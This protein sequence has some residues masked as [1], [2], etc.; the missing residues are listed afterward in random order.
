MKRHGGGMGSPA[1]PPVTLKALMRETLD[2]CVKR[3]QPIA[4][5]DSISD[6]D[7]RRLDRLARE[8]EDGAYRLA[9]HPPEDAHRPLE[10]YFW[11]GGILVARANELRWACARQNVE[12]VRLALN[13]VVQSCNACHEKFRKDVDAY[14]SY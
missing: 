9:D 11:H 12:G 3:L 6:D 10:E 7:Y 13:A 14:G 1:Q 5:R 4:Q 8:L 2:S